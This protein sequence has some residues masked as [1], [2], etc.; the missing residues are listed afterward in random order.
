MGATGIAG[1]EHLHIEKSS[2]GVV[3]DM[4]N[5]PEEVTQP[6]VSRYDLA[7]RGIKGAEK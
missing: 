7:I 4:M 3:M 5:Q 2:M 1:P 6:S